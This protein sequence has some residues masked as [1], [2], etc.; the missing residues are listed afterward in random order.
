MRVQRVLVWMGPVCTAA[1]LLTACDRDR[2]MGRP[3]T[4]LERTT[5]QKMDDRQVSSKVKNALDD[6]N[7]YKFPD[8]KVNTY[9]GKIQLSGFVATREQKQQAEDIAKAYAGAG[10]V[11]NKIT[12]KP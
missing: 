9:E 4:S 8:V 7:A 11:E 1:M 12:V 6:N 5:G 3:A 2:N 10:N